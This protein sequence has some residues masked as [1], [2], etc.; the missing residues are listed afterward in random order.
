MQ[1]R[2]VENNKVI[3]L[4]AGITGLTTAWKLAKN[5]YDITVIEKENQ[6]GGLA[7]TIDWDGWKFDF[8][9][10]SF[11]TKCQEIT[12]LF[13]ELLHDKFSIIKN[14]TTKVYIFN[15]LISYP[16]VGVHIFYVMDS[17]TM[18]KAGL[19]F[20]LTRLK[21][22][23]FGIKE[24][25]RLDEWIIRRFG[26]ML[27]NIYFSHYIERIQKKSPELLSKDL[28]EKKIPIFRIRQYIQR[29][30]FKKKDPHP[31]DVATWDHYYSRGGF[32]EISNFL[33]RE[34]LALGGKVN[35]NEFII[36]TEVKDG[37]VLSIETNK[38]SYSCSDYAIISTI[39]LNNL[40]ASIGNCEKRVLEARNDLEY[41]KMRFLLIK[42][43]KIKVMGYRWVN[44]SDMKFPFYRVS[45]YSYDEFNIVPENKC[46]LIFEMPLSEEDPL[47]SIDDKGLADFIL[48]FFN[49][50]FELSDSDIIDLMSTYSNNASPI[51]S[52]KYRESLMLTFDYIKNIKNLYSIGRQGLFTYVNLDGC[53]KM[54]LD[55]ADSLMRDNGKQKNSELLKSFHNI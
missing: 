37:E 8:G 23:L 34:I 38:N 17:I 1:E 30:I 21:A 44:F 31:E 45:E 32:G 18:I 54:G 46:S 4:G 40:I 15:K 55:F 39:P 27:F 26:K 13:K 9:A 48:P 24:T 3:I 36:N 12:D 43:N 22:L 42:V 52:L 53:T 29:E 50:V 41:A 2:F 20:F 6:V 47:W 25:E 10:H 19:D 14:L 28:G 7:G 51:M 33:Y 49:E 5:G 11:H 16:L 35:L